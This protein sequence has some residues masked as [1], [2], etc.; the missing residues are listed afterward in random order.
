MDEDAAAIAVGVADRAERM[1]RRQRRRWIAYGALF[2]IFVSTISTLIIVLV[3]GYQAGE[4]KR[5]HDASTCTVSIIH[6]I[7][8]SS[9]KPPEEARQSFEIVF[10][11]A[12]LQDHC[13]LTPEEAKRVVSE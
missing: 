9:G 12:W 6:A 11:P 2:V 5:N 13:G 3:I 1:A 8:A 4:A 7:S 10:E